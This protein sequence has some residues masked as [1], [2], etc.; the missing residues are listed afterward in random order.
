MHET[1]KRISGLNEADKT[2]RQAL[3]DFER[4]FKA[5]L[6]PGN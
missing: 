6:H 1:L 2:V 5:Y 3:A 4:T